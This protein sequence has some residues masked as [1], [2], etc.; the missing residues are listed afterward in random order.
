MNKNIIGIAIA[1]LVLGGLV[2]V[3]QPNNSQNNTTALST[4]S[5]GTIIV[6]GTN[7]YDFGTISMSAGKV[8]YQF[9]I[10]NTSSGAVTINKIYTS[11]M[12]T[13]A[14]LAI[15]N[16]QFGPYGM[17]GHNAVP[18]VDQTVNSNE[19]AIVEIVFDPAAHGPAGVGRIQR[20][21]TIESNAGQPI[22][23]QFVAVVTP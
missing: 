17:P 5:N 10:K 2:W 15:G 7:S 16:K 20:A 1:V 9:K 14:L 11:C 3:A 8:K 6:E 4:E 12:C 23:L 19:E 21:I 22:L 18:R 13:T